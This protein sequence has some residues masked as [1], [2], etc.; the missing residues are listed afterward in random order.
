MHIVISVSVISICLVISLTCGIAMWRKRWEVADRSR[1]FLAVF[2]LF[3]ALLC[4]FRLITFVANPALK[5]YHE[6]LAPFLLTGGLAAVVLYQAYPIEVINPG[7]LNWRRGLALVSPALIA[8]LLPLCGVHYQH[9]D[10][11]GDIWPRI[12]DFD[13]LVRLAMIGCIFSYTFLLWFIPY[14]WR[15]SNVDKRWIWR[16]NLIIF[17]MAVLFFIQ[18]FTTWPWSFHTHVLWVCASFAY[19]AYFELVERLTTTA[20]ASNGKTYSSLSLWQ[21]IC[22]VVDDWEAWRNPNTSVETISAAIG[23]NRIYVARCVKEHTGLTVNDYINQKR[24]N[25]MV[26]KLQEG[27]LS[28]K[29][30]FYTAGFRNRH[31]AYRNFIKFKGVS[32]T[33]YIKASENTQP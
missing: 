25:Y 29:E 24:V 3:T 10:S 6:V 14:N 22:Q 4:A 32:P 8:P 27:T 9:L 7:F 5:P 21:Q 19:F 23:T 26:S 16:T 18:V 13:I 1:L 28:H 15:K 33:E 2:N 12:T 20:H 31:T 17:V 30:V 11:I